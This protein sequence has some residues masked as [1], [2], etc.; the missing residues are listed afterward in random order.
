MSMHKTYTPAVQKRRRLTRQ[1]IIR[2]VKNDENKIFLLFIW[3]RRE[4]KIQIDNDRD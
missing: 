4:K 1:I 3:K 2:Q